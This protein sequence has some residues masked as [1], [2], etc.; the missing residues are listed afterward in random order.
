MSPELLQEIADTREVLVET[1]AAGK[2]VRTIIWVVVVDDDVYIRTAHGDQSKWYLRLVSNPDVSLVVGDQ[3][4]AF[5]AVLA[6][7]E[8]TVAKVSAAYEAK[9]LPSKSVGFMIAPENL[10]TTH[11]LDPR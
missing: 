7:D 1:S 11:R 10:H 3:I 8:E 4:V 2:T 9:Y 5:H 6:I